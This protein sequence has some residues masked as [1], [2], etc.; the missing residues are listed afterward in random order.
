MFDATIPSSIQTLLVSFTPCF[1]RPGFENFVA[2]VTGWIACQG[3]HHI[4]RV[5]QAAHGPARTKHH[6][7]LYRF[8][9]RGKWAT[10]GLGKALFQLLLPLLPK[11]ITFILDDT[12]CHKSGPHIFG[13]AMHFDAVQ[14]TYG[15]GTTA[16]R[17][18]FFAFGHN[19]VVGAVWLPLPWNADR[20]L[21]IPILFRLYRS[22][23]RCPKTRYRK[24]TELAL[25]LVQRLASWLPGDRRIHVVGDAEYS[26]KTLVKN[27]PEGVSYTGPVVMDAA[28]YAA[29]GPAKGKSKRRGRPPRKGKRLPSPKALAAQASIPWKKLTLTIYAKKVTVLVKS[30]RCLWYTVAGTKLTRMV[31]TRDPT[32]R[33]SDRAYFST[34]DQLT[35]AKILAQFARRWEI[36]VAFRNAKQAMGLQDPQ[37]GWWRRKAGTPRPKKRPGPNP[38]GRRGETAINHTLALPFVAYALVVVWYF[39]N[40]KRAVDVDRVR[41]QAPWYRHKE[42]PSFAD[43]LAAVRR[44]LWMATFSRHPLLKRVRGNVRELLPHWLLAG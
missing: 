32:G 42:T 14:S 20:G 7:T 11:Q 40:G 15:R 23:K 3:R 2:L 8:F 29:L 26:C 36:E 38:R 34:D 28:L 41:K 17:K 25:E 43:M 19:W 31:L 12:L 24:R 22:K 30:Q 1:S 44:E 13:A 10:D 5:I 6:S 4:S 33:I 21:A 9:S 27:L 18:G 16:G 37:N 35:E 39:K